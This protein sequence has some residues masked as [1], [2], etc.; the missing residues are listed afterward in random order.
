[1]NTTQRNQNASPFVSKSKFLWG[2]QCS[3]LLWH[4]YNAKHLIP[5]PDA[6]TQAIF[7]QGHRVGNL[8]KKLFTNSIEVGQ[9]VDDLE[10]VLRLTQQAIKKRRPLFEAAF[11][12]EGGFAK[13][14]VLNPVENDAW[15]IIEVK[16]STSVTTEHAGPHQAVPVRLTACGLNCAFCLP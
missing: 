9:G 5:E 10:E 8:A 16:S 13:A 6:A 12:Y 1:V 14:D 4:A 3:K 15:D 7:S 11:N 2:L